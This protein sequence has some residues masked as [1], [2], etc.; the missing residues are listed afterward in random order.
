MRKFRTHAFQWAGMFAAVS[1]VLAACG[2]TESDEAEPDSEQT[3]AEADGEVDFEEGPLAICGSSADINETY[4]AGALNEVFEEETGATLEWIPGSAPQNLTTLISSQG[5]EPPCDVAFL[6][7]VTQA[8][9]IEAGLVQEFDRTKLVESGPQLEDW[10]FPQPDHG[11]A[12]IVIRLGTCV[13]TEAYEAAG[14]ELPDSVDDWF[15]PA[16]SG[17]WQMPDFDTF[18]TQATLPALAQHYGI[19]YD[20]PT[21]FLA[22]IEEADPLAFWTST[23]DAQQSLQSGQTWL[24]PILDGRCLNLELQGEPV[25][26][27]PLNLQID[28]EEYKYIGL[29]DTWD[30]VAGSDKTELAH[31]FIDIA[32]REEAMDPLLEDY[33]YLPARSDLLEE[34]KSDP[35]FADKV[36]DYDPDVLFVP[37]YEEWFPH[38]DTWADAWNQTFRG[39]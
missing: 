36:G 38:L 4:Q 29:L 27:R 17:N 15:D 30:I 1:L 31:R 22:M 7:N 20:D 8:R 13:N 37:N 23:G 10:A 21:E 26:F 33:G 3:A 12:A 18:Y 19:P 24:T 11:P 39:S 6:D 25:S 28:G 2:G 34:A 32:M 35:E 14:L 9:A 5:A 16:I